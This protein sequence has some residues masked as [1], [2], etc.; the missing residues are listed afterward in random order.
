MN[1][2]T[3]KKIPIRIILSSF[4][5]HPVKEINNTLWYYA[6]TRKER[7][8]SVKVDL[9]LNRFYD[10][11]TKLGGSV[12]DVV[13][14]MADLN[15]NDSLLF[16]SSFETE[17]T[18]FIPDQLNKPLPSSK[19]EILKVS[20]I[21]HPALL[22]Y[23][24]SRGIDINILTKFCNEVHYSI[25]NKMFFAIGFEN[26]KGGFELRNKLC[27]NGSSPK[28]ITTVKNNSSQL[29]IFEG[30]FDFLSYLT[31]KKKNS[32]KYDFLILNSIANIH[33]LDRDRMKTYE[34][35][36]LFLDN[37]KAGK[38]TTNSLLELFENAFDYSLKYIN[39][40][41]LNEYLIWESR[42]IDK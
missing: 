19:L 31:L 37:D 30:F 36:F 9:T 16:L 38:K 10:F 5:I 13:M 22:N 12:I 29:I 39:H 18:L 4:G 7:T 28:T 23:A 33:E 15:F 21:T 27:K 26:D 14:Q 34:V 41:D 25:R 42:I 2:K 11:A 8:A 20:K 3:L 32:S 1:I 24:Q 17:Q 6:W 35:I 40:N